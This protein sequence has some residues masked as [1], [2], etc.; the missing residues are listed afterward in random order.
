[1]TSPTPTIR[2]TFLGATA[3]VTGSKCLVE[4]G[5]KR[6]LVPVLEP[7]IR[8]LLADARKETA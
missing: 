7:A 8:R 5:D 2:L 6:I 3:T 1:M 4:A